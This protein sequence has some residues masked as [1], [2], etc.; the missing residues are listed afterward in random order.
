MSRFSRS[1]AHLRAVAMRRGWCRCG[2]RLPSLILGRKPHQCPTG[3]VRASGDWGWFLDRGPYDKSERLSPEGPLPRNA[4]TSEAHLRD[5]AMRL[6]WC[7]CRRRPVSPLLRGGANAVGPAQGIQQSTIRQLVRRASSGPVDNPGLPASTIGG[8]RMG[9]AR[10]FRSLP[11]DGSQDAT[12]WAT[13]CCSAR[14]PFVGPRKCLRREI[15]SSV[16]VARWGER[17][18]CSPRRSYRCPGG[19]D[20]EPTVAGYWNPAGGWGQALVGGLD[21]DEG[22]ASRRSVIEEALDGLGEGAD[23]GEGAAP[24]GAPAE[25]RERGRRLV[26]PA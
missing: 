25:D 15:G 13:W 18:T 24:D 5:L 1:P 11:P 3:G 6:V 7:G 22:L 19:A 10:A 26:H 23:V 8:G 4:I 20:D 14:S 17:G 16:L 9:L 2:G 12:E 21:R